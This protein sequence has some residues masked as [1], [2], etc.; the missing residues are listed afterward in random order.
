MAQV[1]PCIMAETADEYKAAIERVQLFAK[2]I[3]VD[4]S[5]GEFA[6]TFLLNPDQVWWP[7]GWQADIHAMVMRPIEYVDRLIALNPS[8]IIF[9]V[10]TGMN[11]LPVIEK[12]KQANI[13]AG[14]ALL[15][16]TVPSGVADV[17]KAVDHVMIFSGDL[18]KHGGTASMM[19]VEKVR[20]IKEI[21]PDV[22]IGWDGG[23]NLENAFSIARGG[24]DVLNAGGV[25]ASAE[26]PVGTYNA[27]TAEIN[28]QGAI[29]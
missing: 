21:N 9:H 15:R 3:H 7:Q 19:Q 28:K 12:I 17:I 10:E 29:I 2:R 8:L 4:V 24:V 14:V 27:M 23:V 13:Q 25:F 16:S 22:E 1:V 20:L 26:S 18:G 11:L 6:P 5:D